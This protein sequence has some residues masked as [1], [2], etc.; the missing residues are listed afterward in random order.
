M[1]YRRGS[2]YYFNTATDTGMDEVPVG[3]Q[4][5]VR[6]TGDT[7]LLDDKTGITAGSTV[8]DVVDLGLVTVTGGEV[9][10]AQLD[11]KADQATTYT[12]TEVDTV[13]NDKEDK[14]N[15]TA[16]KTAAYSA[17]AKDVIPCDT[18]AGTFVITLPLTPSANDVVIIQDITTSFAT[19][20]LT[21]ARNGE[22]IMGL[23]ED[24]LLDINDAKVEFTYLNGDWRVSL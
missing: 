5:V 17:Q 16:V 2:I 15:Y 24:M 22:T 11:L 1:G 9:S 20:N 13:V 18:T 10:E 21:V 8:Q 3:Y 23:A 19:N 4:V 7:F 6:D 14:Y 12:R